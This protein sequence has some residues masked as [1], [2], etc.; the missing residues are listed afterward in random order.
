MAKRSGLSARS[1]A[2]QAAIVAAKGEGPVGQKNAAK[3]KSA[4]LLSKTV[5]LTIRLDQRT[6]DK[7]RKLAFD[8]RVSIQSL[9]LEGVEAT[10]EKHGAA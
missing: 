6:H 7:L 5:G 4:S 3:R 1:G 10:L 8:E 2:I 9:L